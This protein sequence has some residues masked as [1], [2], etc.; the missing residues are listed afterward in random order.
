MSSIPKNIKK[1]IKKHNILLILTGGTICSFADERGERG[2]D[3]KKAQTLIVQNFRE[4]NSPYSSQDIVE[5]DP[6]SPLDILSENMTTT[7]W[8]VLLREM[9]NY[10][11]SKYDGVI[12]LHGTDT[13]A[14]TASLL[15]IL[16]AGIKIPVF[17]ISSQLP[18]YMEEANG[19]ANF[20]AAVELIVNGI[21]PNVYAVYR[22]SEL[23]KGALNREEEKLYIHY[24]AH[25]LQCANHSNN[26][27]SCDMA[28]ID[29]ENA[30][31]EGKACEGTE[32]PLYT[33]K[34]LTPCVLRI[35]PYVGLDYAMFSLE[36]VK[37]VLHGTYHSSTVSVNSYK[38]DDL[39]KKEI[40]SHSILSLKQRC[41]RQETPIPLFIEPCNEDAYDYETTGEILRAGARAI[42]GMTSEMAYVK[43]LLGCAQG[44]EGDALETYIKT[45]I[46][47]EKI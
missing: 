24:G 37:A 32:L 40:P 34:E 12:I 21:Q 44:L 22:N 6:V 42:C 19:N 29:T 46:N 10:D 2:S 25:L 41:D 9:R 30:F 7:H 35:T 20:K 26:F 13:L 15:S 17:M 47:G 1:I 38:A 16:L 8:N 45:E 28:E 39:Q 3:T 5:F 14:Y 43:L 11:F 27:Y 23:V 31:F 33:C 36:K 18:I 4:C